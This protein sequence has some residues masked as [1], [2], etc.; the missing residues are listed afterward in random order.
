M[1]PGKAR[2][3]INAR[4][5]HLNGLVLSRLVHPC[6]GNLMIDIRHILPVHGGRWRFLR[7]NFRRLLGLD[8]GGGMRRLQSH[9]QPQAQYSVAHGSTGAVMHGVILAAGTGSNL[10]PVHQSGGMGARKDQQPQAVLKG[11]I[12]VPGSHP[13]DRNSYI[14]GA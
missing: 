11:K 1:R 14:A 8:G 2:L 4:S 13:R 10:L 6:G 12:Q 5:G 7:G 9:K 3:W